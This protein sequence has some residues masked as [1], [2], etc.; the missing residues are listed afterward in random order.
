MGEVN[1]PYS[2]GKMKSSVENNDKAE[3]KQR[4]CAAY[5]IRTHSSFETNKKICGVF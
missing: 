5:S 4:R 1:S 3:I 2:P